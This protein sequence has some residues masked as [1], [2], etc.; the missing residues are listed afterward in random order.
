MSAAIG[1]TT[2]RRLHPVLVAVLLV[3]GAGAAWQ[4]LHGSQVP[5][6]AP[7]TEA[8]ADPS[9]LTASSDDNEAREVV[10]HDLL[11]THGSW[12]ADGEIPLVFRVFT[13]V[14]AE[15]AAAPSGETALAPRVWDA[16]DPP[17]LRL[18]VVLISAESRR[19]VL[20]GQVVGIGDQVQD[21]RVETIERGVVQLQWANRRLTYDLDGD[22]PREFRAELARRAASGPVGGDVGDGAATVPNLESR[23]KESGS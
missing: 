13:P 2:K 16:P 18:G 20:G 11:A 17:R 5:L 7:A 3:A 23:K 6:F 14:S 21:A 8:D 22:A 10:W 9:A 15:V 12:A 1:A 19:A 4:A